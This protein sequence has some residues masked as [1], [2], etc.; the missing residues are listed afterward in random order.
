MLLALAWI[1]AGLGALYLISFVISTLYNYPEEAYTLGNIV[2]F[3]TLIWAIW[4]I[5][6][7]Y[8]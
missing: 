7:T 5:A 3:A 1:I 4:Y 2:S 8:W 6:S